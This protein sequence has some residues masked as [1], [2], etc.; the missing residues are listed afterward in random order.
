MD[1]LLI[2]LTTCVS[3]PA[4]T[5]LVPQ[6]YATIQAA[7]DNCN[8]TDVVIVAPGRYVENIT[9]SGKNFVLR[10]A[11]PNVTTCVESTII[12]GNDTGS[13]VTFTGTEEPN[14]LLT[15]FTITNGLAQRGAG[16]LGNGTTATVKHNIIIDNYTMSW[17]DGAGGALYDC[18]GLIH[19]NLIEHNSGHDGAGLSHCDGIIQNCTIIGHPQT[20]VG[21][22]MGTIK[23]CII[24]RNSR[25]GDTYKEQ[26]V[27]SSTPSYC[28][29]QGWT[30]GGMGNIDTD[31][32]FTR[33]G[34]WVYDTGTTGKPSWNNTD[35]DYHLKSQAGRWDANEGRW[36]KD[37]VTSPCIDAGDP[38][39]PIGLEPSP[40][41]GRI[42]MGAYGG[43]PEAS[44]SYFGGPVCETIIAGD[45]NGDCKVDFKDF[46]FIAL[47]WLE[48]NQSDGP[49]ETE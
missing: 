19:N 3:L 11:N 33:S 12:D 37:D 25:S 44:K 16:V 36:T 32:I 40:N 7:I 21:N 27:N 28:L 47:H 20:P 26:I 31:P 10:S 39:S 13:V 4:A 38:G 49:T 41:G 8:D 6:Q 2:S 45:I 17:S 15:G 29:V 42:N 24:W 14:C 43:T 5:R 34:R 9:F 35:S 18:D 48:D 30:G 1:I 46:S 23:N 22:C